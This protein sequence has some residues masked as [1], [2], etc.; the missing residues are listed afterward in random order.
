MAAAAAAA[1]AAAVRN[2]PSALGIFYVMYIL[3]KK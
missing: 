2:V 3:D 1:A